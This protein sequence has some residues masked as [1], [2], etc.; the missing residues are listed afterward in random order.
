[1]TTANTGG[2]IVAVAMVAVAA[3]GTWTA[4]T[5]PES[6]GVPPLSDPAG[7]KTPDPVHVLT[8]HTA[9]VTAVA[10]SPDGRWIVTGSGDRTVRL[11][12]AMTGRE[13]RQLGFTPDYGALRLG[14]V[15]FTPDGAFVAASVREVRVISRAA[16]DRGSMIVAVRD[17][18]TGAAVRSFPPAPTAWARSSRSRR[19]SDRPRGVPAHPGLRLRDADRVG[20]PDGVPNARSRGIF[21][22]H[23][24]VSRSASGAGTGAR[25]VPRLPAW[26]RGERG[27]SAG[28]RCGPPRSRPSPPAGRSGCGP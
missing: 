18:R 24:P 1:M 2:I 11:W 3:A 17:R 26:P 9:G 12:D 21:G 5:G 14:R 23:G 6:G 4:G 13:E 27:T 25:A 16:G 10:F 15:A 22:A 19:T 7:V 20:F 28:G 8:G